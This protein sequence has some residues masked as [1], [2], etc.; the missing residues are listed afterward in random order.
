MVEKKRSPQKKSATKK[1]VASKNSTNNAVKIKKTAPATRK[2]SSS[3]ATVGSGF[4]IV[5][6]G[7]SAGGLEAFEHFFKRL[8]ADSGIAFILVQHLDPTHKSILTDL[9]KRATPM[10]VAEVTDDMKVKPNR[11]YIIPPNRDMAI[12]HGSLQ[13]IEPTEPRGLRLPI[14]FFF[15]NVAQ[16][17]GERAICVV[18]S[19]TGTDGTLGLKAV[20]E[21]GGM[22]MVQDPNSAKYDGMPRS[23]IGT[24]L[25]DFVMPPD[26]M[27][28]Q[29]LSFVRHAFS[30]GIK[31]VPEPILKN[32]EELNKIYV[33]LRNQTGHDFSFYKPKTILRRIERRMTVNQL[34]RLG[35]YVHH[36]QRTPLEV[37]TLFKELLIGVSNFFRDPEAFQSLN[38][39]VIP[40]LFRTGPWTIR[41]GSGCPGAPRARRP[42][43]SPCCCANSWTT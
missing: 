17:Q 7:A 25:A 6:I 43:R 19:G 5:S 29:L 38:E 18:L 42:I 32:T 26:K 4:P 8:P 3:P 1:H 31:R 16:D 24:G 37:E 36:L 20:K 15:R 41:C 13:L 22:V 9:V 28:E 21:K 39:T 11:V 14:D 12:L 35:D 40:A 30:P 2:K 34:D 23:A 27:A 33:L 10:E